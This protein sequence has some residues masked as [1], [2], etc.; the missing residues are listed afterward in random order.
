[1]KTTPSLDRVIELGR[2]IA[3]L[4]DELSEKEQEL[5]DLL[6]QHAHM[7]AHNTSASLNVRTIPIEHVHPVRGRTLHGSISERVRSYVAANPGRA[8]PIAEII[9]AHKTED[10]A[11]IRS[12]VHR[13]AHGGM[14]GFSAVGHGTYRYDHIQ[15]L[16]GRQTPAEARS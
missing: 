12:T 13:L 4:R 15:P 9:A 10:A 16:D 2:Q 11:T 6:G 1:M 14:D 7:H 8:V 5:T 3:I